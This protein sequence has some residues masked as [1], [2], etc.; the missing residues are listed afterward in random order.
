M[1]TLKLT[2][3][4]AALALAAPI[5][6]NATTVSG[7]GEYVVDGGWV[8]TN[9][10]VS[11][12][13]GNN[14]KYRSWNTDSRNSRWT[15]NNDGTASL[16]IMG[17]NKGSHNLNIALNMTFDISNAHQNGYCQG[18]AGNDCTADPRGRPVFDTSDW[19][20]FNI[21][22]GSM[23]IES[24]DGAGSTLASVTYALSDYTNGNHQP[25]LGTGGDAFNPDEYGFSSWLAWTRTSGFD[26]D[27]MFSFLDNS[28]MDSARHG[29]I[30]IQLAPVPLPAGL[31]L[32]L[33]ALGA[34]G[35]VRR[36]SA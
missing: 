34:T 21:L 25:Q 10:L 24:E 12:S 20:Y 8:W 28:T 35:L 19:Q 30:N 29:D 3:A 7:A 22:S 6:A 4:A 18:Y 23:T 31:V 11:D 16:T 14:R 1:K 17:E 15:L 27:S 33:G 32:M 9:Q 36:K 26:N 5:A 13:S 2:A